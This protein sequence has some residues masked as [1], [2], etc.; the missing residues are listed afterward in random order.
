[1]NENL[2][3]LI[4]LCD[5]NF[6]T[7]AFSHSFGM[8]S[9]IQEGVVYD[10]DT[11]SKWLSLYLHNQ[12]V[13]SDG[14]AARLVYEALEE[15]KLAIIW[16][17]DRLLT[18]QNFSE[19][20]REGT[21]RIGERMLAMVESLFDAELLRSY[22][23]RIQKKQSFGHPAIVF[24]MV[25]YCLGVEKETT[26]Q[27]YLYSAIVSLVQNAVRAIPLGQTTG[28]KIIYEYQQEISK[29]VKVINQLSENDFGIV[30]PGIERSQM[31]HEQINIRIFSS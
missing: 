26:N 5:S 24:T 29:A 25:G 15:D 12:L 7:G 28:Q 16:H 13:Y 9:Y 11:F 8:E 21:V 10:K 27:L 3:A 1:M 17:L 14:L 6:P 18:V 19:E 22:R 20:T 31:A 30:A 4:Q 23:E 2:L